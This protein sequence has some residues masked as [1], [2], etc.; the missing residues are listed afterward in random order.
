MSEE[1]QYRVAI[2]FNL[3]P[4]N[5]D[6]WSNGVSQNVVYLYQLLK[7]SKLVKDVVMVSWGPKNIIKPPKGFQLDG[8]G[9]KFARF[10]D[11]KDKIDVMIEGSLMINFDK[12]VELKN[13]GV[14]LV[15]YKIGNDYIMDVEYVLFDKPSVRVFN[16]VTYN[17]VWTLP[18][19]ENM[20]RSYFSIMYQAD[21]HVVPLIWAPTFCDKLIKS[22]KQKHKLDFPYQP[23]GEQSK[24][25]AF[26]EPNVN[27]VKTSFT[28]VLICEQAYR[29]EPQ[30]LKHVYACSTIDK[31]DHPVMH[32][33]IGRT[34]IV[35]DG[36]MS[37]EGRYQLPDFLSRYVDVVVSHQWENGLNYAYFDALYGGY[38]FVHNS[39]F[40]P[41]GVGYYYDQFDAFDGA[42]ALLK[43]IKEHDAQHDAYVKRANEYLDTL[44][45][46]NPMNI[47]LYERELKRLFEE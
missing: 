4:N 7:A 6:I 17:A 21:V 19:H 28:P 38:P 12:A 36:I 37:V 32:N 27:V 40:L 34:Q 10:D 26:F 29:T 35:R 44:L 33:F 41:K 15:N 11:V 5:P 25:V 42:K 14:K 45:P 46:T 13:R 3:E 30:C 31:K 18:H 39:K 23:T 8:L 22:L 47:H 9:I 20:C 43:A 16:G 2:T 1:K 24:R